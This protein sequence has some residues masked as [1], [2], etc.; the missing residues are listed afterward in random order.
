MVN[1]ELQRLTALEPL[2]TGI[3]ITLQEWPDNSWINKEVLPLQ[4]MTCRLL[5]TENLFWNLWQTQTHPI[6]V[7]ILVTWYCLMVVTNKQTRKSSRTHLRSHEKGYRWRT[8]QHYLNFIAHLWL[9]K[10]LLCSFLE[11]V[12]LS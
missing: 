12:W 4:K 2:G 8:K 5:K 1:K 11:S 3:W 7:I 6:Y 10:I 9:Q